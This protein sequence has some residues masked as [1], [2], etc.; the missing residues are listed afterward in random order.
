MTMRCPTCKREAV[1]PGSP[2]RP[3]CSERCRLIDLDNW[4]SERY[5]IETAVESEN[6][7]TGRP[8]RSDKDGGN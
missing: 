1:N 4:L 3:F 7:P 6:E 8:V 5:R 2:Y